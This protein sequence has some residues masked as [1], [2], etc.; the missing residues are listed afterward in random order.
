MR[1]ISLKSVDVNYDAYRA[2]SNVTLD[3][4]SDDFVAVIGPNGGGKSTL[5][6]AVLG[7]VPYSH[8]E[9]DYAPDG[10]L[11]STDEMGYLP[12]NNDFD[13]SFPI[14]IKE[15][16]LSGV[17][18]HD[19]RKRGNLQL[20]SRRDRAYQLMEMASITSVADAQIG[21]VSGGQLQRAL[22]CRALI[23]SPKLLILDEPTNFVDNKFEKE[24]YA[25]LRELS[26]T[27][28]IVIVSHDIGTVTSLV[29]SIVCVNNTV[30]RHDSNI[31]S[32]EQLENYD[33]PIQ[34][35]SH[36]IIP[37]TVLEKHE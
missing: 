28:S 11:L 23:S 35:L 33:C 36:G 14:S 25:M 32:N 31:I 37:H 13:T 7:L 1:L 26:S 5:V 29:K 8:G 15:V 30:H 21:E 3:I 16:I 18:S 4:F 20:S 22:L 2:L 27:T 12:Q 10:S 17:L 24:L 34:I 19:K 9:I 6:K